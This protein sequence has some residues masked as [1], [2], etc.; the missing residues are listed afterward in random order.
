MKPFRVI[1]TAAAAA[2][3]LASAAQ[4]ATYDLSFKS[5]SDPSLDFSATLVTTT[6]GHVG[7]TGSKI[8]QTWGGGNSTSLGGWLDFSSSGETLGLE[9]GSPGSS[10][11]YDFSSSTPFYTL[12][13]SG[14]GHFALTFPGVTATASETVTLTDVAINDGVI[15]SSYGDTGTLTISDPPGLPEPMTWALMLGGLAASGAA[16]RVRRG[17]PSAI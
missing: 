17:Q 5:T 3:M 15:N 7:Y 1:A 16:L 12:T 9:G 11:Y 2:M 13:G 8:D 10:K 4:A 14:A 6:G